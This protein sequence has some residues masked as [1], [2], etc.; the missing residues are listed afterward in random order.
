MSGT[1]RDGGFTL[2]ETL[3]ALTIFSFLSLLLFG[4]LGFG[5]RAWEGVTEAGE[6]RED[7][8]TA[9]RILRTRLT[10][11]SRPGP[12]GFDDRAHDGR[13][14]GT[15]QSLGFTAY[16]RT[17]LGHAGVYNFDLSHEAGRLVFAWRPDAAEEPDPALVGRRILLEDVK[18]VEIAFFGARAATEAPAWHPEWNRRDGTPDLVSV[19]VAFDPPGAAWP[20]LVIR[21]RM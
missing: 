8:R 12:A 13:L 1:R 3:V 18:S 10:H 7:V 16:W 6:R 14:G 21:P 2:V 15:G 17:P 11:R 20:L 5:A 9:Q 19:D 4:G